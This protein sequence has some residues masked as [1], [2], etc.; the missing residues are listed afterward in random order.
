MSSEGHSSGHSAHP[1]RE[2]EEDVMNVGF[3]SWL[4]AV[5]TIIII[6]T[7]LVLTGIYY[8]TRDAQMAERQAEADAR[9]TDLEAH[10]KIDAM[11]IEGFYRTPDVQVGEEVQR[12]LFSVPVERGMREVVEQNAR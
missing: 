12:G 7:V 9:I 3:V 4:A 10:R 8:M 1:D 6:A 11:V 5:A 2:I